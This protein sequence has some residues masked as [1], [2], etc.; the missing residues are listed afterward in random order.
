MHE[1]LKS[2]L[3]SCQN[4]EKEFLKLEDKAAYQ[5]QYDNYRSLM[6]ACSNYLNNKK[7]TTPDAI[8]AEALKL[9]TAFLAAVNVVKAT[10]PGTVQV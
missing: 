3:L 7:T 5:Q 9:A 4:W 1:L 8:Q 6:K 2:I 10:N